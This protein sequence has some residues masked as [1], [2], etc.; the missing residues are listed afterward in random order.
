MKIIRTTNELIAFRDTLKGSVGLV[1]TMGALHKGHQSLIAQSLADNDYTF[2]SIFVNP[3]QFAPNE[4]LATY[5]RQLEMDSKLCKELG[6]DVVFAPSATEMYPKDDECTI[7]APKNMAYILEGFAR[8]T[9]F[10]GV[11]QILVKLFGLTRASNAYFGQ[12]DAQQL[13]IVKRMVE[14]LFLP[15]RINACPIVRDTDGLALSSRNIY[16]SK[17]ERK[18]ALAIPRSLESIHKAYNQGE[19]DFGKLALIALEI[20]KDLEV[21]YLQACDYNLLQINTI[22]PNQSLI[23]LTARVG[24]VRL[25]DNLWL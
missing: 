3:T 11:L 13:L 20:L 21:E 14:D 4:D 6:V 22:I 5:P 15:I 25:L 2:V 24:K 9:H 7:L 10:N 17:E 12:K 18:Q 16:L 23:V 8:P 1:P 19:K